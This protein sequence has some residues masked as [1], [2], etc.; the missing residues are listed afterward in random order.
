MIIIS[1]CIHKKG[2]VRSYSSKNYEKVPQ[3]RIH[4][5]Y[6][7]SGDALSELLLSHQMQSAKTIF[8]GQKFVD[9]WSSLTYAIWTPYSWF[10]LLFLL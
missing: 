8:H 5:L 7:V 10:S 1:S 3:V 2:V 9:S 6:R 4:L